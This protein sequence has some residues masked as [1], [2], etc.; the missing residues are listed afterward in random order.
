MGRE[1]RERVLREER[2]ISTV[3]LRDR[4]E[5]RISDARPFLEALRRDAGIPIRAIA[6][7]KRSSPTAGVL[8]ESYDPGGIASAYAEA[9]ARAISVLTEPTRF[10]GSID[11]LRRVRERVTVPV[12]LKDFVVHERQLYEA[13]A[14]GADAALLIVGLL[15]P[16][17]LRDFAALMREIALAPL[18]ELHEVEELERALEIDG[19]AIG[20]N[21]R[22]L[23]KLEM[24]RGWAEELLPRIPAERVRIAESGYS[25]REEIERLEQL[26]ADAVLLGESLLRTNAPGEALR[27]LLDNRNERAEREGTSP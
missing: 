19:A 14:E 4:A 1:R 12:L 11:D 25:R 22:D 6:E 16:G 5:S 18:V 7:V 26:G 3:E 20:V 2:R 9:G 10:G 8:R 13:K 27:D 17:Q 23:R 15:G 21:N 24:R